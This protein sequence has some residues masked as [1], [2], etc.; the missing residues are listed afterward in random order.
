MR[1]A[2][3]KVRFTAFTQELQEK[4][5]TA[6]FVLARG[7][8][9]EFDASRRVQSVN[10]SMRDFW[11]RPLTGDLTRRAA[12]MPTLRY[13]SGL[14]SAWG[15]ELS[16]D[17]DGLLDH[18]SMHDA[19]RDI[20]AER[21]PRPTGPLVW[22][23]HEGVVATPHY[24]PSLNLVLQVFG[25]KRWTLWRPDQL[26]G[27]RLHP[28]THPSRRQSRVPFSSRG[29]DR[30]LFPPPAFQ[31]EASAGDL[32]FVPPFWTHAV[33]SV[34]DAL[35][36][37]VIS[38]SWDEAVGARI[39]W[40]GLPFGRLAKTPRSRAMAIGRYLRSLVP[41]ALGPGESAPA[42]L[43][44]VYERRHA[45]IAEEG[46]GDRASYD[47]ASDSSEAAA[48]D[49]DDDP[50]DQ[51]WRDVVT[52]ACEALLS[53]EGKEP[54]HPALL[55]PEGKEQD[56]ERGTQPTEEEIRRAVSGAVERV[57]TWRDEVGDA[58]SRAD[59]PSAATAPL[60]RALP[61]GSVRELLSGHA[62]ELAA[63]AVGEPR[64][65]RLLRAWARCGAAPG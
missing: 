30:R 64:H 22:M 4:R 54:L 33:E 19:P 1:A 29:A 35:S 10:V 25:K 11:E 3:P 9:A 48:V 62:E 37:S 15:E 18:F 20:A 43:A 24:D 47:E 32:L 6:E 58:R 28:A 14:L 46:G 16:H 56:T 55:S 50:H 38:P 2:T 34:T 7:R 42:F 49:V 52:A 8:E 53:P 44:S 61:A 21:W 40:G 57:V 41:A 51:S 17:A 45:P 26:A 65:G 31:V 13:H 27:L 60:L 12:A 23:G 39:A 36:L 59:G 5:N 63:W